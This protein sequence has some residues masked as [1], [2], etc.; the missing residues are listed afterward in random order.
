[1]KTIFY[2][3]FFLFS[4]IVWSQTEESYSSWN[5][6][7]LDY[8]LNDSFILKNEAHLRRTDF[9]KNKQQLLIRPSMHY[10]LNKTIDIGMGYTY[11]K[12]Y[13]ETHD[14]TENDLWE[15]IQLQHASWKL[16]FKHRFRFEQRFVENVIETTE[17]QFEIDGTEFLMRFRYRFTVSL[18]VI[19][20]SKSNM[21]SV[22][23][24][25]EIWLNTEKGIAPRSLNQNWFYT[26]L[27]YPI[28]KNGSI[29]VGYLNDYAPIANNQF[30]SNHILQTTLKYHIR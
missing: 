30:R 14:F 15:Q 24:F 20:V 18:P 5:S 12:N 28:L 9:L 27:S 11:A 10:K 22:T 8:K 4:S 1:M 29:S 19:K 7:I 17:N 13:R 26:G 21:L 16:A 3:L 23:M 25:N 6:L 2:S